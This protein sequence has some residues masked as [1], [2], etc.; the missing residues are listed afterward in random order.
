MSGY[1]TVN[2]VNTWYAEHGSGEPL[3]LLHGGMS[4]Q[5]NFI[6]NV[7]ALAEHFHVYVPE[8]RG[9]GHTPDVPGPI[10]YELMAQDTVAFLDEVVGGPCRLMGH[11]DGATIGLLV[12]LRRPDLVQRLVS[13]SG[14]IH[15]SGSVEGWLEAEALASVVADSYAAVSPDGREHLAVVAAK[16]GRMW[17]EEPTMSPEVLRDVAARTLV[18]AGDDD[19]IALE[20]TVAM[21]RA[22]PDA[23]LAVV[24][25]TSHT[26]LLEK[27]DLCNRMVLDFLLHDATP[28]LV[29][30]RRAGR[31]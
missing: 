2:G 19:G 11:S 30:L 24:P 10:T 21:F 23:E 14:S 28:T 3:V 12:A 27:P 13:V 29:P 20:H 26:L 1:V 18:M 16:L 5:L 6:A 17:A 31:R 15:H 8:R 7:D 22:I 9:H 4:D 25:G